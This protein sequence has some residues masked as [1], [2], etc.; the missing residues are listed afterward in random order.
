MSMA[1]KG[2]RAGPSRTRLLPPS[3]ETWQRLSWPLSPLA[4]PLPCLAID[5]SACAG[6]DDG[7]YINPVKWISRQGSFTMFTLTPR[8]V[9]AASGLLLPCYTHTRAC[10]PAVPVRSER[11]ARCHASRMITCFA[12]PPFIHSMSRNQSSS[13]VHVHSTLTHLRLRLR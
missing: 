1:R 11:A 3:Y 9:P 12:L 8:L 7:S 10:L 13:L 5:L 2:M 6:W 4:F